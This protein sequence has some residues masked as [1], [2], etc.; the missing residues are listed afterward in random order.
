M[1]D[2]AKTKKGGPQLDL[3]SV[4]SLLKS[5]HTTCFPLDSFDTILQTISKTNPSLDKVNERLK[6]CVKATVNKQTPESLPD[7]GSYYRELVE[8]R[9]YPGLIFIRNIHSSDYWDNLTLI[10]LDPD[11]NEFVRITRFLFSGT[12][13]SKMYRLDICVTWCWNDEKRKEENEFVANLLPK[14]LVP[15][16]YI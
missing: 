16:N 13:G 14:F 8:W 10:E 5:Y 3:S 11:T 7:I 2:E 1:Q 6:S 12:F 15:K 9:M 4:E